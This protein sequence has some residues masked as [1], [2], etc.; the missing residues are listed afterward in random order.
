VGDPII[1]KINLIFNPIMHTAFYHQHTETSISDTVDGELMG[2]IQCRDEK[3]LE[4][5]IKRYSAILHSVVARMI[6][7]EQDVTDVVEEVF[8][9]V[10]NQ[11]GNFDLTKGKAIGWI[12]TMARRRAIDRV[13]RRQAHDRA[14]MRFRLSNDTGTS[15]FAVNDVEKEA[16]RSDTA[17]VFEKLIAALPAAQIAVVRM[18]FYRGLSHREIARET[19]IPLGTVKTRLELGVKKLRAAVLAIDSR[20]AWLSGTA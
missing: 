2:R 15:H 19:G 8:L 6:A 9:G 7:A 18:A 10:W 14:E 17:S 16:A 13:R 12:I 20:E 1:D 3:A 4:T 5:L 11:A